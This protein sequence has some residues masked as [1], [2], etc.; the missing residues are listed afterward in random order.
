[1]IWAGLD[2][3]YRCYDSNGRIYE[4]RWAAF[5]I[6]TAYGD[7]TGTHA[8]SP[9][10]LL[11]GF[12][13]ALGKWNHF[14]RE[15]NLA[16]P[17]GIAYYHATDHWN[18]K[19]GAEFGPKITKLTARHL[20]FGYVIRLKRSVYEKHYIAGERTQKPQLDTSYSV[21]FRFLVSFLLTRLPTLMHRND[22]TINIVLEAGARGHRDCFRVI[23]DIKKQL[24]AETAMLGGLSFED[25]R[26]FPG[27][28]ASD[29]LAFG[30]YK[31]SESNEPFLMDIPQTGDL[32]A[33]RRR[34][35][36]KPPIFHCDLDAETLGA[37]KSDILALIDIRRRFAE[38][39]RGVPR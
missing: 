25:K 6:V 11:S 32:I 37:L 1:M 19:V 23:N 15:W 20:L 26:R 4:I 8:S 5:V 7:E 36:I 17:K 27:L 30:S 24:P 13:A 2:E 38:T 21:C 14:D 35:V 10:M 12:V 9:V 22:L 34:A 18:S 16:L 29:A 31:R 39:W 28:Q 3:L 33:A